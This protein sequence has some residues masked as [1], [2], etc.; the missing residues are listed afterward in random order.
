MNIQDYEQFVRENLNIPNVSFAG[1]DISTIKDI[2]EALTIVIERYPALRNSICAIGSNE[3]IN[4][5]F[6]L[7]ENSNKRKEIKWEDFSVEDG[8]P[9]SSVSIGTHIP[10]I[11]SGNIF[12]LQD[13]IALAYGKKTMYKGIDEL[14]SSSEYNAQ[15]GY[16][17]K[18]CTTFKG[19]IFHEIGHILDFILDFYHDKKLFEL[20]EQKSNNFT[21]IGEKISEYATFG[22]REIIAE[23]FA[24]YM[25][26][27][28]SNELVHSIG[29][30]IDKKYKKFEN[31]KIFNINQ[32]FSAH[33][34]RA[35]DELSK[36]R[37]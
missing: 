11:R 17:P 14:N 37:K 13:Y 4:N 34:V 29:E 22:Y 10:I 7:I 9:M 26:C 3:D 27:P 21:S 36:R 24:E 28:D 32:K 23:A 33:L 1:L 35:E 19:Y 8:S 15:F 31:S 20:I 25:I 18:H 30:Y 2:V 12:T 6:N 16:H 5:Q